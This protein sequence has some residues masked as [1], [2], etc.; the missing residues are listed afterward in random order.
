MV[1]KRQVYFEEGVDLAKKYD[2]LFTETSAK[3]GA[4]VQRCFNDLVGQALACIA[5]P[6]AKRPQGKNAA[7]SAKSVMEC[8]CCLDAP[9]SMLMLPCRHLCV[10]EDCAPRMTT[11]P[12]CRQ[13]VAERQKIFIS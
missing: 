11:C 8:V 13:P 1:D 5:T 3:D 9:K 12:I 10:C 7:L 2:L 6:A 4:Y